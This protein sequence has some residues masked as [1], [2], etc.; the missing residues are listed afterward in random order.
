MA[1]FVALMDYAIRHEMGTAGEPPGLLV[2]WV[3]G[4]LA[5]CL[6]MLV[7]GWWAPLLSGGGLL[8]FV[9]RFGWMSRDRFDIDDVGATAVRTHTDVADVVVGRVESDLAWDV[10]GQRAGAPDYG[11]TG[12]GGRGSCTG[13][14][15]PAC[16]RWLGYLRS[17]ER[18]AMK[19]RSTLFPHGV[20]GDSASTAPPSCCNPASC[21]FEKR[22]ATGC[23][24][25]PACDR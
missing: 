18:G 9:G 21:S 15:G 5:W 24:R 20:P 13:C 14:R 16:D 7:P 25:Q 17:R 6:P 2:G 8:L 3:A 23:P 19:G 12:R 1:T 22:R 10:A 4:W 11:S